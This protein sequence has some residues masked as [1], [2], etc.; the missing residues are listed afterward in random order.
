M[1]SYWGEAIHWIVF[2][3]VRLVRKSNSHKFGRSISFDCRTQSNSIHG[4]SS[5]EFDWVRFPNV[6]FAMPGSVQCNF[7]TALQNLKVKIKETKLTCSLLFW[8]RIRRL[9]R[10]SAASSFLNKAFACLIS[11]SPHGESRECWILQW[12]FNPSEHKKTFFDNNLYAGNK[13]FPIS[14]H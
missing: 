3:W 5:I 12:W 1:L 10:V 4:L 11:W 9:F 2:D 13:L 14:M 8:D 6:R 7:A